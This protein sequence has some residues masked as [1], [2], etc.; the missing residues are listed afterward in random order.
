[1]V[2]FLEGRGR[3]QVGATGR[4][5]ARKVTI[6][7]G[8]ASV[9]AIS[10]C[11]TP[12]ILFLI[13]ILCAS[14]N[15][16]DLEFS[17]HYENQFF[18][19]RLNGKWVL[20]DYNKLRIDLLAEVGERVTFA[21]DFICRTFHGVRAVNA[22]D[23][24]PEDVVAQYARETHTPVE[25]LRPLFG[26][27]TA[28][29]NVLDNAYVTLYFKRATV[30]IGKQQLPWGTG[31][32]WNPTDI[33][34]AKDPMDPTYEKVGVN[35][36]KLEAPFGREGMLTGILC[37][38]DSWR[39]TTKALKAK[40]HFGG[41]DL[42]VGFVE[43]AQE[44]VNYDAF[45][46][47]VSERR[48]LWGGDISGELLGMGV[49]AEV[50]Y[51]TM[52]ASV[53]FGQVLAGA[54]HTFENGL[55]L[56]GEYYRNGL[57]KTHSQAYSFGDWMRLLSADGENLGR[58]CLYLGEKYAVTELLDWS[59]YVILNLNDRSGVFFPWFDYNLNDN[60]TLIF[61]GYFPFGGQDSEYGAFGIGGLA[62]V[63]VYF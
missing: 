40:G 61:A 48:R 12:C 49:W 51:N 27:E 54:D 1:M 11:L 16:Q 21:G 4:V 2:T 5:E 15:A 28:D 35:A 63:R 62:R 50:A 52:A 23:L 13:L 56:I 18:P 32:A 39:T 59:N 53:D 57:G 3:D 6:G 36:F 19:Q 14:V 10:A 41:F 47:P 26:L 29:E 31:Y 34:N 9:N 45:P 46:A 7:R 60:T 20:Q 38:G 44:G 37:V 25:M 58:D 55:Y 42:S 33:F 24:V 30:R 22:L 8:N 17:G 43:K